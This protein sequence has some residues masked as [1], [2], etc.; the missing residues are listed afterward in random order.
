MTGRIYNAADRLR[1]AEALGRS[2]LSDALMDELCALGEIHDS[3]EGYLETRLTAAEMTKELLRAANVLD[4]L[5]RIVSRPLGACSEIAAELEGSPDVDG[6]NILGR[7]DEIRA[8]IGTLRSAAHAAHA[9]QSRDEPQ[10]MAPARSRAV[11]NRNG[12][13]EQLAAIYERE[14]GEIASVSTGPDK[15]AGGP[16]FRFVQACCETSLPEMTGADLRGFTRKRNGALGRG[17]KSDPP[18]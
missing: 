6:A 16:F 13:W 11:V 10:P 14:T 3:Y 12:W 5:D 7:M 18:F 8:Y 15:R 2:D 4:D 9:R 1:M 17:I